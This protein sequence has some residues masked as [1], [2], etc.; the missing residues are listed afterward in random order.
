MI[1][2]SP[3]SL[4]NSQDLKGNAGVTF[5]Q[6]PLLSQKGLKPAD[7]GGDGAGLHAR[8]GRDASAR[9]GSETPAH[10][11]D[12]IIQIYTHTT[13][14]EG[15]NQPQEE[16]NPYCNRSSRDKQRGRAFW[17]ISSANIW[18]NAETSWWL[19]LT[20]ASGQRDVSLSWNALRTRIGR[21]TRQEIVNWLK[22]RKRKDYSKKESIFGQIYYNGKDLT[23]N[24]EFK[25]I[26]IKTSEGNGVYH[27][28]V[29]GDFLPASWL[30]FYWRKY[31]SSTQLRIERIKNTSHSKNKLIKYALTQYA[32]GQDQ[33]VRLSHSKDIFFPQA[34]QKWLHLIKEN[35]FD[36]ALLMWQR[37]MWLH[38]DPTLELPE[39]RLLSPWVDIPLDM[40]AENSR[41]NYQDWRESMML[42]NPIPGVDDNG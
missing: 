26:A 2:D 1:E 5:Q 19:T 37:C 33:F 6:I 39:Q 21:T 22:D 40:I 25:Y 9:A 31:H 7:A 8:V 14:D 27:I 41:K 13:D 20:S 15:S 16:A 32:V 42:P 4:A 35:G 38:L 10:M 34:R 36:T 29:F 23:K 24:I 28:F 17:L 3:G 12:S 18:Y 11:L 30:R